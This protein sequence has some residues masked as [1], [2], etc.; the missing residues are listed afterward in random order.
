MKCEYTEEKDKNEVDTKL[1]KYAF[2]LFFIFS[3]PEQ[4]SAIS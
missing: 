2:M 1:N 3:D 4:Y